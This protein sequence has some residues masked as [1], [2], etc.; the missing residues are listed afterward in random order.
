MPPTTVAPP[1]LPPAAAVD[2]E[3]VRAAATAMVPL[4][5]PVTD[6]GHQAVL[7]WRQI[8]EYYIAPETP[9]LLAALDPVGPLTATAG[10]RI[11]RLGGALATFAD[12]A[13]PIIA[14]LRRLGSAGAVTPAAGGANGRI[15]PPNTTDAR[16]YCSAIRA[17]PCT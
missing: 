1:E 3:A 9:V 12:A 15:V 13:E 10:G 16:P 8:G 11:R 2:T 17:S 4:G 7:T 5:Q 14:E 6:H